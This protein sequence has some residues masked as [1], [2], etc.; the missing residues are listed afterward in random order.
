MN[1]TTQWGP[2]KMSHLKIVALLL[3]GLV[4]LICG[5]ERA[6]AQVLLVPSIGGTTAT[7][8]SNGRVIRYNGDTG[9]FIDLLFGPIG[10]Q[11]DALALGPDGLLYLSTQNQNTGSVLRINVKTGQ[12]IDTFIASI[13]FPL[14]MTF[15]PDGNLYWLKPEVSFIRY[16]AMTGLLEISSMFSLRD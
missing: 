14:E 1:W 11:I 9:E 12:F 10:G 13:D 15:G 5:A 8:E 16:A 3:S 2:T 4:I 7:M 6:V